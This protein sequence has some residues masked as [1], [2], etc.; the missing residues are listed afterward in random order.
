MGDGSGGYMC[1]NTQMTIEALYQPW[2]A[3]DLG[4]TYNVTNVVIYGR[5]HPCCSKSQSI[6]ILL[7]NVM[8]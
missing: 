1:T 3:V 2:W 8:P 6:L 5:M 4:V 7:S